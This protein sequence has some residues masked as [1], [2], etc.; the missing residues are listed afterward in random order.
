MSTIKQHQ[1]PNTIRGYHDAQF[2]ICNSCLWCASYLSL[3]SQYV[4]DCPAC[5][6]DRIE[7]IPISRKEAYKVNI[8]GSSVSMEFW[9]Q[10]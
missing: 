9:N 6:S 4:E 7:V 5:R 10:V 1:E 3:K 8:D 2:L